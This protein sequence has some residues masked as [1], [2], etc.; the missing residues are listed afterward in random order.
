MIHRQKKILL[1]GGILFVVCLQ[2]A[3]GVIVPSSASAA[4]KRA[5]APAATTS[6]PPSLSYGSSG[7][8]VDALQHRLNIVATVDLNSSTHLSTDGQFGSATQSLVRQVQSAYGN[9]VSVDGNVG[10]QTW[11]ILGLC[12]QGFYPFAGS[13]AG[14]IYSCPPSLSNGSNSTWV[15]FLQYYLNSLSTEGAFSLSSLLS[16]DGQFG[17]H[18]T[19]AVEALQ[20]SWDLHVDG[21][22]GPETWAALGM[23]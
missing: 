5:L 13:L 21:Q 18:T 1:L 15:T 11:S 10:P 7:T 19:S 23:C 4:T 3:I 8:W 9:G 16:T 17:S 22:V 6:C 12:N 14:P 20:S 2:L